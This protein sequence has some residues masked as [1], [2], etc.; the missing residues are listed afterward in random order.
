MPN[1]NPRDGI[2]NPHLTT[3]EDSYTLS[4]CISADHLRILC[5]PLSIER[6]NLSHGAATGQLRENDEP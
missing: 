2:F 6:I 5:E 3:I 4:L 1:S